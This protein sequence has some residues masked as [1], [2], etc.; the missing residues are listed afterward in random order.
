MRVRRSHGASH[1]GC[2][3]G[4][5]CLR[6]REAGATPAQAHSCPGCREPA[7]VGPGLG[8]DDLGAVVVEIPGIEVHKGDLG[9]KRDE[10][11][12]DLRR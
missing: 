11:R 7:H 2:P 4:G 10:P 12:V 3:P 9:L 5:A 6:T 1:D 8:H